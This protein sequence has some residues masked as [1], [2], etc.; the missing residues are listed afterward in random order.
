MPL[1]FRALIAL[2][3]FFAVSCSD[4]NNDEV[5]AVVAVKQSRLL[6]GSDMQ[7][8]YRI[9]GRLKVNQPV[10]MTLSFQLEPYQLV[11]LD[12]QDS[13]RFQ[14]LQVLDASYQ[15]DEKGLLNVDVSIMPVVAGKAYFKL[16][17]ATVDGASVRSFAIP[18]AVYDSNN[19]MPVK[20]KNNLDRINLPAIH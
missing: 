5:T 15:A 4:T 14:W 10:S 12:V 7:M 3:C 11:V 13:D 18:L 17:A 2:M 20:P 8:D 16:V 1:I 19:T 6:A 9:V